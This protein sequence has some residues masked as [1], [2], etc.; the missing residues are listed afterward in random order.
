M[1]EATVTA[2]VEEMKA[3]GTFDARSVVTGKAKM[4]TESVT[5][6]LD[7]E[8]AHEMNEVANR[9]VDLRN[10]AATKR[11]VSN[12]VAGSP[13]ADELDAEADVLEE[14]VARLLGVVRSSALTF[15]LRGVAP[16]QWRLI[17]KLWRRKIKAPSRSNFDDTAEGNEEYELEIMERNIARNNSVN[18]DL[19]SKAIVKVT[20][21][22][23][24]EDT[25]GW[26][27]EDVEGLHDTLLETEWE[28]LRL[29]QQDLT[30]A[31]TLFNKVIADADF[32]PNP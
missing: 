22:A 31:H 8:A 16:V 25:R 30:F 6:Y 27:V 5:L 29:L 20:N 26:T 28:K 15:H 4:A 14:E 9:I 32:L 17:D 18:Y 13:E 10:D 3:P 2:K 21:A 1:S 7:A 23:G 24:D 11:A 12:S 19:V